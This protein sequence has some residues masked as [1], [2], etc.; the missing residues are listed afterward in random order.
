MLL[1]N[2]LQIYQKRENKFPSTILYLLYR[3][4]Q[5]SHD[6][7]GKMSLVPHSIWVVEL[8]VTET[9]WPHPSPVIF[10]YNLQH[11]HNLNLESCK[12]R[13]RK[14]LVKTLLRITFCSTC[15]D[16]LTGIVRCNIPGIRT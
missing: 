11:L 3:L 13:W 9:E 1:S 8:K 10:C 7:R 14:I 5:K 12:V 15:H 6:T 2:S 4:V 16:Y